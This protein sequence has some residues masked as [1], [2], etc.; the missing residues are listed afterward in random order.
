MGL[1]QIERDFIQANEQIFG[2]QEYSILME[3]DVEIDHRKFFNS[4]ERAKVFQKAEK[5]YKSEECCK[6]FKDA[7]LK[8]WK[9]S[10]FYINIFKINSPQAKKML[11]ALA[12]E[13][14]I[15]SFLELANID[16]SI[17]VSIENFNKYVA[18]DCQIVEDVQDESVTTAEGIE[19]EE[20]ETTSE[21]GETIF[22]LTY[23]GNK[24]IA[25]SINS[26]LAVNTTNSVIEIL[27]AIAF[28]R[29]CIN[30]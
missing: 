16:S 11:K 12:A 27:E 20:S 7:G 3:K 5:F 24:N 25:L 4:I 30:A 19:G 13:D 15:P 23:K 14:K 6:M 1:L 17:S 9:I 10:D 2:L 18:N 29:K 21:E 28:L 22:T 8:K 26:L